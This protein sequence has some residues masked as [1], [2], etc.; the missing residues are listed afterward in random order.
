MSASKHRLDRDTIAAPDAPTM[1]GLVA[2]LL[3]IPDWLMTRDHR[4]A[5]SELPESAVILLDVAAAHAARLEPQQAR[6]RT[7]LRQVKFFDLDSAIVH[8]Y[9]RTSFGHRDLS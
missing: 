2:D 1:S 5:Q 6:V 3:D 4:I 7:N 8:L 9:R